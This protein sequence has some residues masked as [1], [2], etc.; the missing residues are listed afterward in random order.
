MMRHLIAL[1]YMERKPWKA[2]ILTPKKD[3]N[4]SVRRKLLKIYFPKLPKPTSYK[5]ESGNPKFLPKK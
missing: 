5:P 4:I 3:P 2:N 1:Y